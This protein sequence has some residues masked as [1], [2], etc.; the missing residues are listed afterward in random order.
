MKRGINTLIV[1]SL[2]YQ[3]TGYFIAK[4]IAA[5]FWTLIFAYIY[6][7]LSDD[8]LGEIVSGL[9]FLM[10]GLPNYIH[11]IHSGKSYLIELQE[12]YMDSLDDDLNHHFSY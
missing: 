6:Y 11:V 10:F 12:V 2:K 7:M 5:S 3:R 1:K 8:V 4:V 9:C